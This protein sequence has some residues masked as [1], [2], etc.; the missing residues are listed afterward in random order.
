MRPP[1]EF[2]SDSDNRDDS[3]AES[4]LRRL[5][6]LSN[7]LMAALDRQGRFTR[8]SPSWQRVLGWSPEELTGRLAFE[9]IHPEDLE[10]TRAL[11]AHAVNEG[12]EV[13]AFENRYRRKD[14]AYRWLEWNARRAGERW[15]AVAR[16]ITDR[17]RLQQRALRDPLTGLL[18]RTALSERLGHKLAGLARHGGFVGVLV[19]DLDHFRL[20]NDGHGHDVGDLCLR[21]VADR[22]SD[23]I[24]TSDTVSRVGGD[25]FVILVE[26]ASSPAEVLRVADRVVASLAQPLVVNSETLQLGGSVGVTITGEATAG[27]ET[28][29]READIAMYRAKA[30]GGG[31]AEVFD[32]EIRAELQRGVRAKRDLRRA[33]EEGQLLIHYQPIVALPEL[34]VSR[35]EALV[36]WR[37]P[38]R[39]V[40]L[41]EEFIPPA[42]ETELISKIGMWVLEQSCRQARVW[43][44]SGR[45]VG[46]AVNVSTHQLEQAG[47]AEAVRRVLEATALPAALLCVEITETG[48]MERPADVAPRLQELRDLGVQVAMDDF[49]TGHSSLTYL[50]VLPLDIIKIDKSYVAGML[51]S[52][53]DRAIVSAIISL[54]R[55]TGVS[56]IAEGVETQALHEELVRMGCDLAQGFFYAKPRPVEDLVLA[57]YSSGVRSG[58]GDP[59]VTREPCAA[60]H[61][62]PGVRQS[63]G[64][65]DRR[66]SAGAEREGTA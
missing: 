65:A 37:H 54:A 6:T 26:S 7:D 55:E 45:L 25:E 33:I 16:D 48:L 57:G 28:A 47:F 56:A 29:L 12:A 34:S 10:H 51:D 58:V 8:A 11:H 22:L 66:R 21:A 63:P 64:C 3:E 1:D 39:G 53:Q 49:G 27:A 52:D 19:I 60:R 38:Q 2:D 40:L 50:K 32:E 59:L 36:R 35:C 61:S 41:P 30:Q 5:F 46:I 14:G 31:C 18:N 17:K 43:Q 20:V 4:E 23:T 15:Y 9:L 24:R 42:E 13:V 44:R 62:P